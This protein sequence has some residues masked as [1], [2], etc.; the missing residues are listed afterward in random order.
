MLV[1]LDTEQ[2]A[3]FR[4]TK[5]SNHISMSSRSGSGKRRI[6]A[7][8]VIVASSVQN[9]IQINHHREEICI[10]PPNPTVPKIRGGGEKKNTFLH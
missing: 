8:P 3:D 10:T 6:A 7:M 4:P 5:C 1:P 9:D 2:I